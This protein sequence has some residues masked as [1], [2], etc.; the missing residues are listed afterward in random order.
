MLSAVNSLLYPVF[1]KVGH[2]VYSKG[3]KVFVMILYVG[4]DGGAQWLLINVRAQ[5]CTMCQ[6][7]VMV[8]VVAV[9][10]W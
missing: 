9:V 1:S 3:E 7:R 8:T 4:G 10:V 2:G 6:M 5:L